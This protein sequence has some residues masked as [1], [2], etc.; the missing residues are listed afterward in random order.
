MTGGQPRNPTS[1]KTGQI[2]GTRHPSEIEILLPATLAH[3]G[4]REKCG[5]TTR[6]IKIKYEAE[7]KADKYLLVAHGSAEEVERARAVLVE[8]APA[9]LETHQAAAAA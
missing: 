9:S 3:P 7:L 5:L 2:W 4:S 6:E 8:T 1:A